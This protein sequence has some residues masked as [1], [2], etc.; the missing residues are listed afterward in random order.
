[1]IGFLSRTG[2]GVYLSG[3]SGISCKQ[4]RSDTEFGIIAFVELPPDLVRRL[5]IGAGLSQ[6]ALA[7]R[8]ATSQPAIAR[9]ERGTATPSWRTLER[10]A[11]ACGQRVRLGVEPVPDPNDVELATQLLR[12]TP[13]QRLRALPRFARLRHFASEK[14]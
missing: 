2:A 6:R 13:E 8:A 7:R 3:P 1:V 9:Y 4:T 11:S 14:R 5:R 12:L 10:I